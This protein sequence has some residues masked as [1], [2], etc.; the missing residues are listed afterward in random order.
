MGDILGIAETVKTFC[1][2]I[3]DVGGFIF[4]PTLMKRKAKS[5]SKAA[6]IKAIENAHTQTEVNRITA[7]A[8]VALE[9]ELSDL[10]KR[11]L[12][13]HVHQE[14]RKQENIESISYQAIE[15]LD[16]HAPVEM[17]NE[18]WLAH[19]FKQ[20]E[21]ISDAEM[22]TLWAKV[23]AGEANKAGA[24][25]KRTVDFIKTMSKNEA[26]LFT[27]VAQGA[28]TSEGRSFLIIYNFSYLK[29]IFG[30]NYD[31]LLM[32][33]SIGLLKIN[34]IGFENRVNK[35][36]LVLNYFDKKVLLS[37]NSDSVQQTKIS[38]G[39]LMLTPLGEEL[40]LVCGAQFNP[41]VY[42]MTLTEW[43]SLDYQI[44]ELD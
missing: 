17:L 11:A 7:L 27:K 37:L 29:K 28:W 13:R 16:E 19:F 2:V 18:D 30:L 41:D 40:F 10:E 43:E 24:F 31:D 9:N 38:F 42:Q 12:Q 4:E 21:T 3:G 5:E 39:R 36:S 35:S 33:E 20:C 22:Q 44:Q 23:L 32:L 25:S 15:L 6:H 34:Q 1:K 14:T 26:E 8:E